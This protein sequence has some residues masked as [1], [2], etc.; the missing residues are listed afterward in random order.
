VKA[1]DLISFALDLVTDTHILSLRDASLSNTDR[2]EML[3]QQHKKKRKA[4]TKD[5]FW[6]TKKSIARLIE[7]F[8]AATLKMSKFSPYF[9]HG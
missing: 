3:F 4:L 2:L 6:T 5:Q 1:D 7:S 9:L 8:R